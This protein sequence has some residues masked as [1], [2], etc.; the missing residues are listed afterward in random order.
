M[1][2]DGGH[3][4]KYIDFKWR[5]FQNGPLAAILDYLFP[6]S[7]FSL[8]LNI[9]SKLQWHNTYIIGRSLLIFCDVNFKMAA[10]RPF[11]IFWFQDSNFSL[12]LD[13]NSKL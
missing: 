10:W 13:I 3:R 12:A 9:N 5:H 7:N 11:W 2:V 4:Q 8:A 1:H 6:D